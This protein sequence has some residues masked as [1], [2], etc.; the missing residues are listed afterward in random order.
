MNAVDSTD[1]D[2]HDS[3]KMEMNTEDTSDDE[4]NALNLKAE[5]ALRSNISRFAF[6]SQ[7]S[8]RTVRP[9]PAIEVEATIAEPVVE[10]ESQVEERPAKKRK[11]PVADPSVYAHLDHV[12]DYIRPGLD[13]MCCLPSFARLSA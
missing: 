5:S 4:T 8:V 3:C 2:F 7:Q 1:N 6:S 12:Q 11:R 10:P 13:G 9:R